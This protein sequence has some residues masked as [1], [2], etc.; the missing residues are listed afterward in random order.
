MKEL[1]A[2]GGAYDYVLRHLLLGLC[3]VVERTHSPGR[4][5]HGIK[6]PDFS[7]T[8]LD[9]EAEPVGPEEAARNVKGH[10]RGDLAIVFVA[11]TG[12]QIFSQFIGPGTTAD[13]RFVQECAH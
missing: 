13:Q 9:L 1:N 12:K 8:D 11:G 2:C 6:P 7:I 5:V 10:G 4:D 3:W